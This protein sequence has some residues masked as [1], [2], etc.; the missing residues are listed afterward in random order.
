MKAKDTLVAITKL[1]KARV[2]FLNNSRADTGFVEVGYYID[3]LYILNTIQVT[4]VYS[5]SI[6]EHLLDI[7]NIQ[8]VLSII[9]IDYY[10]L[11]GVLGL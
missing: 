4:S 6:I 9:A 7:I 8:S 1:Y 10:F 5:S 2:K 11:P 3:S